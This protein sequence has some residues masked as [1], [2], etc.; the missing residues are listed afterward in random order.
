LFFVSETSTYDHRTLKKSSLV[1]SSRLPGPTYGFFAK[2]VFSRGR[3]RFKLERIEVPSSI[4]IDISFSIRDATQFD[5]WHR[6]YSS[7]AAQQVFEKSI[8]SS[9][10]LTGEKSVVR[11]CPCYT[12]SPFVTNFEVFEPSYS[13]IMQPPLLSYILTGFYERLLLDKIFKSFDVVIRSCSDRGSC[14]RLFDAA[15]HMG[16]SANN[17]YSAHLDVQCFEERFERIIAI[18][19]NKLHGPTSPCYWDLF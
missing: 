17:S 19:L 6:Y 8:G 12:K 9:C 14:C 2:P 18:V 4:T 13:R 10:R 11:N 16:C 7:L 5:T 1:R 3:L 15:F